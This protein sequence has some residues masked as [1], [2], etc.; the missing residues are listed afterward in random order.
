MASAAILHVGTDLCY[1][2]PIMEYSGL[3]VVRSEC[4]VAAIEDAVARNLPFSAITFHNGVYRPEDAVVFAA[5][6]LSLASSLVLF[7]DSTV[8]CD[9]HLFD[10]VIP[11]L[12]PTLIWLHS[13]QETI[14]EARNM[15]ARA[16]NL[17]DDS[18]AMREEFQS[19]R[20][21]AARILSESYKIRAE[22]ERIRQDP[23]NLK[24]SR[25]NEKDK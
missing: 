11:A 9:E 3:R 14:S 8:S 24:W 1:R 13:L 22:S 25:R 5:R 15:R 2:I 16:R 12:T 10:L 7:E 6:E 20:R 17:H 18:V 21:Q 4:S 19:L 23:F